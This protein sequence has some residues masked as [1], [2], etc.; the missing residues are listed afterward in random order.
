MTLEINKIF[1]EDAIVTVSKMNNEV[2]LI[3]TSPPYNTSR[4]NTHFCMESISFK[5][6]FI[7]YNFT[8]KVDLELYFKKNSDG[9]IDQHFSENKFKG[10]GET[11]PVRREVGIIND[12][13]LF[14]DILFDCINHPL[15]FQ[16]EEGQLYKSLIL[17]ED[18]I[19]FMI[20]IDGKCLY[21]L[22]L[23]IRKELGEEGK[24]GKILNGET[25]VD[26]KVLVALAPY[27]RNRKIGEVIRML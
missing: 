22:E 24:L 3:L 5:Q 17:N 27:L 18:V 15:G 26:R 2:D 8:L 7:N 11:A 10:D 1:N 23:K 9:M 4:A 19:C 14:E 25:L 16:K 6:H 21:E 12:Y 20:L 13:A